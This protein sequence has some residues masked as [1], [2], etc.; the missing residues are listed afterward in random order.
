MGLI[1]Y[2]PKDDESGRRLQEIVAR[3][4]WKDTIEIYYALSRLFFRLRHADGNED[5]ALLLTSSR[6]DLE[7]LV[8]AKNLLSGL[9]IV[10]I[11][12]DSEEATIAQGHLLRPRFIST[13]GQDFSDLSLVL[14]KM[15]KNAFPKPY[16]E[17]E[18]VLLNR[19]G[20]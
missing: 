18:G 13:Q 3:L 20:A 19:G 12:P 1:I 16:S 11:L 14:Q 6:K 4:V 9:R 5:M 15:S 10:L 8:G 7:A 2:I 17:E